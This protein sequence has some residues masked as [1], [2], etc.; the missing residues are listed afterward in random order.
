MTLP[1]VVFPWRGGVMMASFLIVPE[2][3]SSRCSIMSWWKGETSKAGITFVANRARDRRVKASFNEAGL[4][5]PNV[6]QKKS[7]KQ[8]I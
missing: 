4:I 5:I 1:S 3:K 7:H 8:L 6:S 2:S